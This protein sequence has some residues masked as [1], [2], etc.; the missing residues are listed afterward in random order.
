MQA[1]PLCA[2]LYLPAGQGVLQELLPAEP[3]GDSLP[4][5][6]DVQEAVPPFEY[7]P[8]GQVLHVDLP[9]WGC[10]VPAG[11]DLQEAAP[12]HSLYLPAGQGVHEAAPA[13]AENSPAP[14]GLQAVM[15]TR[16]ALSE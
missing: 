13:S 1:P 4:A 14:Q 6:Q 9:A 3:G 8:E 2:A 15:S 16:P 5:A 12:C 7:V 11:Q 10:E